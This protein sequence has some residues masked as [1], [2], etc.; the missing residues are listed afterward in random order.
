MNIRNKIDRKDMINLLMIGPIPP[1]VGGATVSFEQL[2]SKL[3]LHDDFRIKIIS[4]WPPGKRSF[5]IKFFF[6]LLTMVKL[7][8]QIWNF[9]EVIFFASDRG[10]K[11]FGPFI[12]L[13][14]KLS[15][16]PWILRKFGGSFDIMY[17]ESSAFWK[18]IIKHFILSADLCL[19]Q[20]GYLVNFFKQLKPKA[21]I[22]WHAN[23]RPLTRSENRVINKKECRKFIFLGHV[24]PSKGIK[25]IIEAAKLIDR[26]IQIDIYGPLEDGI[27]KDNFK[28]IS[29]LR[30]CGILENDRV[31]DTLKRYDSLIFPT[32]YKGEGYPGVILE[33]YSAGIPVITTNWRS[34]PEIVD[35]NSGILIEPNNALDLT[36]AMIRLLDDK[37]LY[38][39]LCEGTKSKAE[40]FS[41][42]YWANRLACYCKSTLRNE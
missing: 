27:E 41:L 36:N 5:I 29:K 31:L 20:T 19:F 26:N 30:Y 11:V 23:S 33:A 6:A 21:N 4:S 40:K 24:K 38:K 12:H 42:D 3:L 2:S 17:K 16:K 14:S 22:D 28:N 37:K 15:C 35:K 8:V 18:C 25:D 13:I 7:M 39:K 32:Y 9:N 10:T 1:P 34:I